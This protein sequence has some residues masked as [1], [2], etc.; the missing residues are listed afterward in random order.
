MI[1]RNAQP[2]KKVNLFDQEKHERFLGVLF[3][4]V[5]E[6][7]QIKITQEEIKEEPIELQ[8]AVVE[9]VYI[10][11]SLWVDRQ[12]FGWLNIIRGFILESFESVN[13]FS[14]DVVRMFVYL[15][16]SEKVEKADSVKAAGIKTLVQETAAFLEKSFKE[17]ESKAEKVFKIEKVKKN[18]QSIFEI[19]QKDLAKNA[20]S[21]KK[22]ILKAV[23]KVNP[24][25]AVNWIG[26][27]F[28]FSYSIDGVGKTFNRLRLGFALVLLTVSFLSLAGIILP[29]VIA[30]FAFTGI[31]LPSVKLPV[32]SP[33]PIH[34]DYYYEEPEVKLYP[35][36][37]FR[38]EVPKIKLESNIVDNV[39]PNIESEYKDKLQFGVA[40][41]KGSYLPPESGGPVY[42]FAH[43][44]DTIANIAR[45]NAKFFSVRDLVA[46]DEIDVYF[47]GTKY[48]YAVS[49]KE[50]INPTELDRIR[51]TKTDL[52]LQTCWPPGTDWQRLI[53][54]ADLVSEASPSSSP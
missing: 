27:L 31:N 8:E 21:W 4:R 33:S 20:L 48:H 6:K 2:G 38:I 29:I 34:Y 9:P 23:N 46:G 32:P 24:R 44:T 11:I 10:R 37:E 54:Y 3:F 39:D 53:V 43:S 17:E 16:A 49:S 41:A 1:V 42:L 28:R 25:S 51:Q 45:F 50:I 30:S 22:R 52:I 40:H 14:S 47:N 7:E 26:S 18:G 12:I 35:I 15:L 36:T 19:W 5:G 13:G